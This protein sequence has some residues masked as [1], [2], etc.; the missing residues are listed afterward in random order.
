MAKA[1]RLRNRSVTSKNTPLNAQSLVDAMIEDVPLPSTLPA[2]ISA[3]AL[4]VQD[5]GFVYKRFVLRRTGVSIPEDASEDE[6][7]E[8]IG[9]VRKLNEAIQWT[10]GDLVNYAENTYPWGEKY[11]E[12]AEKTGYSEKTL[13]EYAYVARRIHPD[14]RRDD[15]SFGHHQ[16]VTALSPE[17]QMHWLA[18]A[19]ANGWS[20]N[21][22]R[23]A[24]REAQMLAQREQN[25]PR[26]FNKG[27]MPRISRQFQ[28]LWERAQSG[29]TKARDKLLDIIEAHESWYQQVRDTLAK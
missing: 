22:L 20:V 25:S 27:V 4:V 10:I 17:A 2:T 16:L 5:G 24:I 9:I 1:D 13:R 26:L 19:A 3:D 11:N 23:A 29:D 15:L 7:L 18:E 12:L 14:I 6:W 21:D 28:S 8:L